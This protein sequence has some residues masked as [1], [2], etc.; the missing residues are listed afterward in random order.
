M[1]APR[2]SLGYLDVDELG[3]DLLYGRLVLRVI[4]RKVAETALLGELLE[5]ALRDA[6]TLEGRNLLRLGLRVGL[7]LGRTATRERRTV[8]PRKRRRRTTPC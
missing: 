1:F 3:H 4:R 5:L 8:P 7:R 2:V 6:S